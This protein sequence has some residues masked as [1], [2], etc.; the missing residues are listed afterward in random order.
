MKDLRDV[1]KEA[2]RTEAEAVLAVA[3]RLGDLEPVD[4]A[5][6]RAH[7]EPGEDADDEPDR[8]AHRRVASPR[9]RRWLRAG[10]SGHRTS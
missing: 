2:M 6:Q 1:A 5:D 4:G 3:E 7:G 10:V 9:R 8:G